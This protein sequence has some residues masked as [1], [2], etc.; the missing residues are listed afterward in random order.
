VKSEN[1][2]DRETKE[3]LVDRLVKKSELIIQLRLKLEVLR[4]Q[5]VELESKNK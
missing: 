2:W 3:Q 5:I 1:W 4:K